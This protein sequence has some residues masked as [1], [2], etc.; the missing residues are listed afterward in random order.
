VVELSAGTYELVK[1]FLLTAQ[2]SGT[3]VSPVT[4]R[5]RKGAEVRLMGGK[6]VSGFVPVTDPEVLDRLDPAARGNVLQTNLPDQ[7][8]P[9][10][11]EIT[12]P[13]VNQG[14]PGLELFFKGK[15]MTLARWP[16]EDFVKI[17][18][19]DVEENT[20]LK[21]RVTL[22]GKMRGSNE[23]RFVYEGDRPRR[24]VGENDAWLHG[25]W[26]WDW[27][28]Q[29]QKIAASD[30]EAHVITLAG[31]NHG[32]GYRQGQWYYACNLLVELDRPGEWYLDRDTGMLYFWPPEP[33]Q[34]GDASVS[35]APVLVQM[36]E[37]SHVILQGI[38]MENVR[39]T[40]IIMAEGAGNLVCAC[41]IRNTSSG[42]VQIDGGTGHGVVFRDIEARFRPV[43]ER[44]SVSGC[45]SVPGLRGELPTSYRLWFCAERGVFR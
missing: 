42:G 5:A 40:A 22:S 2:D 1:P 26:F 29:R 33:I 18:S 3:D 17:A 9:D 15:R 25:H 34:E 31:P 19:I 27:A 38:R 45:P 32:S 30:T 16:N 43:P 21:N 35:I 6:I 12:A 14:Q 24:W 41:T 8:I 20:P 37:T 11:G 28:D 7:G 4:Y 13:G 39:G 23:G 10:F 36:S 44:R